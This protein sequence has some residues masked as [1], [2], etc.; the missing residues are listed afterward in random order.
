MPPTNPLLNRGW[1]IPPSSEPPRPSLPVTLSLL[2][3]RALCYLAFPSG[4]TRQPT[5]TNFARDNEHYSFETTEHIGT[6]RS[7]SGGERLSNGWQ[8]LAI[9]GCLTLPASVDPTPFPRGGGG[10]P[11]GPPEGPLPI[12]LDEKFISNSAC[13]LTYTTHRTLLDRKGGGGLYPP[14]SKMCRSPLC[15]T[16]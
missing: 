4:L 6:Y 15:F 10:E 12:F 8:N 7:S 14:P 11:K 9:M 13:L 16:L 3:C 5:L 2:R 1:D